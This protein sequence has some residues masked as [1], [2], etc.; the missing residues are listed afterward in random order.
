MKKNILLLLFI[1]FI[2]SL[3]SQAQIRKGSYEK[4]RAYKIAYLTD[5]LNLTEIEAQKFWPF[6]NKHNKKM[7]QLHR[8]EHLNIKNTI[9]NNGGIDNLSEKKSKEI[10]KKIQLIKQQQH[11][12]KNSFYKKISKILS[13]NKVLKLEIYEHE[14]NRKLMKKHRGKRSK[15][16]KRS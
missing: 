5:K 2:Y 10:L 9:L 15:N 6:Y 1:T 3:P 8:E 4:I 16:K 7:M 12:A 11:E 13:F 14:F